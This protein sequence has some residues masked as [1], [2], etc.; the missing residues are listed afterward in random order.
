[1]KLMLMRWVLT[2]SG[3][4]K[5]DDDLPPMESQDRGYQSCQDM[6]SIG[7][8]PVKSDHQMNLDRPKPKWPSLACKISKMDRCP[9]ETCDTIDPCLIEGDPILTPAKLQ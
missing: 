5:S 8:F 6:L 1:M 9:I 2:N 7:A 3:V 4:L